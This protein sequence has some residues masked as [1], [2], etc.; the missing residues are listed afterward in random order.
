MH[1]S[2]VEEV[3]AVVSVVRML[4]DGAYARFWQ[5]STFSQCRDHMLPKMSANYIYSI[6]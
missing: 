1:G 3:R 6:I 5:E 2:F 4:I